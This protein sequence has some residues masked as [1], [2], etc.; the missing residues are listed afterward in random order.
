MNRGD[1]GS[2][3][4]APPAG[5]P[6]ARPAA[7]PADDGEEKTS[8]LNLSDVNLDDLDEMPAPAPAPKA[9]PKRAPSPPTRSFAD[10]DGNEKTSALNLNEINLDDEPPPKAAPP[11]RPAPGKRPEVAS[12]ADVARAMRESAGPS[13]SAPPAKRAAPVDDGNEKTSALNLS[14]M[15]LDDE[16]PAKAPPPKAAPPKAAAP[17][18]PQTLSKPTSAVKAPAPAPKVEAAP[19]KAAEPVIEKTQAVSLEEFEQKRASLSKGKAEPAAADRT[20]LVDDDDPPVVKAPPPKK[21][22]GSKSSNELPPTAG[23]P[24][25]GADVDPKLI[26]RVGADV[27]RVYQLAKDLTLVGR[28]LDADFVINDA[29][30]SRKHFNIVRTLSGWK[31][32]DLGSGNGTKVNGNRV[33][34][35]SLQ[36]GMKVEAGGTTLEWVHEEIAAP[37]PS[38]SKLSA[39]GKPRETM[40][41][42][43]DAPPPQKHPGTLA[44]GL[45]GDDDMMQ[46]VKRRTLS[47]DGSPGAEAVKK[48]DAGRMKFD[49]DKPAGGGGKAPEEKTSFSDIAALEIDPAWEARRQKGRKEGVADDMVPVSGGGFGPSGD[50]EEGGEE[51]VEVKKGGAGK[52]IAIAFGIVAVLGGGFVAADKFANL[53]I[54]FPKEGEKPKTSEVEKPKEGDKVADGDKPKEGDGDKPKEGDGDKPKDGE[55]PAEADV[56]E[57]KAE[58]AGEAPSAADAEE[59]KAD[60]AAAPADAAAAAPGDAEAP[61]ADPKAAAVEKATAAQKALDGKQPLAAKLLFAA[62]LKLDAANDAAKKGL[63]GVTVSLA[64]WSSW[65]TG[66][67]LAAD[68]KWQD[69]GKELEKI[70]DKAA[71]AEDAR[72]LHTYVVNQQAYE[73][74]QKAVTAYD[75]KDYAGAKAAVEAILA[76]DDFAQNSEAAG[77]KAA[78]EKAMAPGADT[79]DVADPADPKG[80]QHVPP[81]DFAPFFAA[82]AKSDLQGAIGVLDGFQPQNGGKPASKADASRAAALQLAVF[83]IDGL[84]S[85]SIE[86]VKGDKAAEAVAALYN[87]RRA[88]AFVGGGLK[89]KIEGAMATGFASLAKKA[90][91]DKADA[92]A[93]IM[94]RMALVFDANNAD[95][96]PIGEAGVKAA[97][98]KVADAKAAMDADPDKAA[99]LLVDAVRILPDGD[100]DLA[101]AWKMLAPLAQ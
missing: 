87:V 81:V 20:F 54:I 64:P 19:K 46:G 56:V 59:P 24:A 7:R 67:K 57:D 23:G 42:K 80:K 28:G 99:A 74:I 63:D 2:R 16:P 75:K 35:I 84:L 70:D 100:P 92:K 40:K 38:A 83:T 55:K 13:R 17:Q 73:L 44:P 96:K 30:A 25:P 91:A 68:K 62:A 5:R 66:M 65:V 52:K 45:G 9:P 53:G 33:T 78:I 29:S 21:I 43:E 34:E 82:Y 95:A 15:N 76:I 50:G 88:D 72:Q 27:G 22:G 58:D 69:A 1:G 8:A 77:F 85:T 79:L 11:A 49:D 51:E 48:R 60:D 26:V 97:K 32:V 36:H 98:Q 61:P 31:L 94:A 41:E 37:V 6:G 10:D 90:V 47:P 89:A 18:G 3:R 101:E 39:G 14:D 71:V 12:P 93:Q 4:P 86:G